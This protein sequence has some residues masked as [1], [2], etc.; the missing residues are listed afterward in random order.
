MRRLA[1]ALACA[2]TATACDATNLALLVGVSRY[3]DLAPELQLRAP[4]NDVRLMRDVLVQLGF[5]AANIEMLTDGSEG[6]L[7]PTHAAILA[8]LQRLAA[9]ARGG[10]SVYLHFSGHG[11]HQPVRETGAGSDEGATRWQPVFL[12]RDVRGWDGKAATPVP[13]AIPD[14]TLRDLIDRINDR[15]AFVFAV[16]DAC[17]SARL[18]RGSLPGTDGSRVRVRHVPPAALGVASAP[19]QEMWPAW[20]EPGRTGAASSRGATSVGAT[21]SDTRRGQAA[22]FYAAQSLELATSLP[23][24]VGGKA[25]WHGLLS[26]HVAQALALGDPLTHRQLGQHIL[27]RYDQLPATSATPLF[28]GDG[29]DQPVFGRQ[30]ASVRQWPLDHLQGELVLPAG[31][32]SGLAEGALLALLADPLAPAA[33]GDGT[34]AARGSTR[35]PRGTLGFVRLKTLEAERALLEPVALQGWAAPMPNALAPGTW[36]RLVSNPLSFALRVAVDPAGCQGNC[37]TARALAR[38]QREGV[39]GVDVRWVAEADADITLRSTDRGVHLRVHAM[40]GADGPWGAP[41]QAQSDAAALD[42]LVQETA[43]AL[44]RVARMRNL[45]Q[46]TARLATLPRRADLQLTLKARRQGSDADL[47]ITSEQL[48]PLRPGDLVVLEARNGAGDPVDLAAFWLSADQSIRRLFPLDARDTP[49]L[50]SGERLRPFGVRI[51]PGSA[52]TERLLVLSMPMRR[53]HEASDFRFLEQSPLARL[54]GDV[55]TE[56]QALFD[57]CFA[58]YRS[59]GEATAALPVEQLGMQ[60]FSFR[61]GP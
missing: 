61:I 29:L 26:W 16:F 49:R 14:T 23:L 6:A 51:D 55:D 42:A 58:D 9:R 5:D 56:L 22:Y 25:V 47:P 59:R 36:A 46:L 50:G 2:A 43:G 31:A 38:L 35:I 37:L 32:L 17:H 1:V 34:G 40:G 57:A 41:A 44:H 15:G 10:D 13:N 60:M 54:R 7:L 52:G 19:A 18:V 45:L 8:A 20:A 24:R 3:P 28:S 48:V 21:P 30:V 11:S 53:G 12:P 4:A 33:T 27:S 39:P